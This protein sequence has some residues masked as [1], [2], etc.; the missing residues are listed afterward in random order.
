[1]TKCKECGHEK[2]KG[3]FEVRFNMVDIHGQF[4]GV[5][6]DDILIADSVDDCMRKLIK[7]LYMAEAISINFTV[8]KRP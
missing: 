4:F 5:E 7:D 1:M 8:I 6:D 3:K 2:V